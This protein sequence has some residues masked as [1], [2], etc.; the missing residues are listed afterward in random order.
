[1]IHDSH[2]AI[3]HTRWATHGGV[4]EKN[5]HPHLDCSQTIAV[6]HNGIIENFGELKTE[7][8]KKGHLF[9]SETDTEV[10]PHLIEAYL[11][12]EG[13]ATSVRDAFNRLKGM[14]A[15]V[16]AYAPSAEIIAAKTGSPLVVGVGDNELFIASDT[17]GIVKHTKNV[18]FLDDN[19]MVI[20]GKGL[21]VLTLPEGKEIKPDMQKLTWSFENTVKGEFPHFLLKE[22]YEQPKVIENIALNY[23][24]QITNLAKLIDQAFGTFML[25]CGTHRMQD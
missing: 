5:A 17:A 19:Q 15:I 1:M 10:I 25:G 22:I 16:V 4:T 9:L 6:V 3:G 14:N 13:F 2:L 7:L 18:I 23:D 21:K 11:K 12:K 24:S 8:Q 20:L